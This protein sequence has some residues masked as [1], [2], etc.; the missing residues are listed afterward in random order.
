[1][2]SKLEQVNALMAQ[3]DAFEEHPE[4]PQADF[5]SANKA[6][7]LLLEARLILAADGEPPVTLELANVELRIAEVSAVIGQTMN[8]PSPTAKA[9]ELTDRW[10]R[11]VPPDPALHVAFEIMDANLVAMAGDLEGGVER[12]E[13]ALATLRALAEE[14]ADDPLNLSERLAG[15]EGS[16]AMMKGALQDGALDPEREAFDQ[17][18]DA[19]EAF[20]LFEPS[21]PSFDS[22]Y[23]MARAHFLEAD[24]LAGGSPTLRAL[25]LL[26]R[27]WLEGSYAHAKGLPIDGAL[28]LHEE[29]TGLLQGL[30]EPAPMIEVT[31]LRVRG[32]LLAALGDANGARAHL[33]EVI[34]LLGPHVA[35]QK[36]MMAT[37][38]VPPEMFA[39]MDR[40][41]RAA[42]QLD[43]ATRLRE[44]LGGGSPDSSPYSASG[45]ESYSSEVD[46]L[47]PNGA[48]SY[49][50]SGVAFVAGLFL[51]CV[52]GAIFGRGI[53]RI[54][55]VL[56][57][58]AMVKPVIT[59]VWGLLRSK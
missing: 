47:S 21:S 25:A 35:G 34:A 56:V 37:G 27:A 16:L 26:S 49:S 51:L 33:D 13:R 48:E 53:I 22:D 50:P 8:L 18:M 59:S 55:C 7:A 17:C 30:A 46:S 40:R 39:L 10:L 43:R 20:M 45:A 24:M 41:V 12:M 54:V 57:A 31:A 29:A 11:E 6:L 23:E 9:R 14:R 1:M 52:A 28:A 58:L 15:A 36:A 19:G 4:D 38:E 32:E 42:W 5:E 2:A 44:A 3:A